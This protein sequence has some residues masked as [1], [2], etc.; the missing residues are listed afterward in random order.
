MSD[1]LW[2]LRNSMPTPAQDVVVWSNP[3]ITNSVYLIGG[4]TPSGAT[5]VV[6][7]YLPYTDTW[8]A[9]NIESYPSNVFGAACGGVFGSYNIVVAGG[10]NGSSALS[11][12]KGYQDGEGWLDLASMPSPKVFSTSQQ[13]NSM[14]YVIGG[15]IG[16]EVGSKDIY[17]FDV[18]SDVWYSN[19]SNMSVARTRACSAFN[20]GEIFVFGGRNNSGALSSCEKYNIA[21]DEWVAVASLPV[22]LYSACC[23]VVGNFAYV[24]GG[25][26][27][28][29][30][31]N[32]YVYAYSFNDN[33]WVV[34]SGDRPTQSSKGILLGYNSNGSIPGTVDTLLSV[35]GYN[36]SSI[37]SDTYSLTPGSQD[38]KVS[39][40]NTNI[41]SGVYSLGTNVLASCLT[42]GV[43]IY[44]TK[45]I[46]GIT[47]NDPVVGS[48]AELYTSGGIIIDSRD[49]Y[50][51]F[52]AVK[53]GYA[54]SN[55]LEVHYTV[56][57][58]V[59]N[60]S[61]YPT[62]PSPDV[63]GYYLDD[64][65]LTFNR[66]IYGDF[67]L[68][69]YDG[70]SPINN[71]SA[72]VWDTD[73]ANNAPTSIYPVYGAGYTQ[74]SPVVVKAV[75]AK[76]NP[77]DGTYYDFSDE[78]STT[79]NFK[80]MTPYIGY[81]NNGSGRRVEIS[82]SI[83]SVINSMGLGFENY[84]DSLY[85]TWESADVVNIPNIPYVNGSGGLIKQG[86]KLRVYVKGSTS[87]A[88]I[89]SSDIMEFDLSGIVGTVYYT[90]DGT[91]PALDNPNIKLYE[92]PILITSNLTLKFKVYEF[93]SG[94]NSYGR[95]SDTVTE[96][97]NIVG[98]IVDLQF[99]KTGSVLQGSVPNLPAQV[100]MI[101]NSGESIVKNIEWETVNT[102]ITGEQRVD[103]I[104]RG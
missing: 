102:D 67:V 42:S 88:N 75:S 26:L 70:S 33:A 69:T 83:P 49:T 79:F 7:R 103:G 2:V 45:S 24:V 48:N 13:Y 95:E 37:F 51:K 52:I 104:I 66:N 35:G 71:V 9:S 64:V 55:V 29:G 98:C 27:N 50:I 84:Y 78:V 46:T 74:K 19:L 31:I 76:Y 92:G 100:V 73:D 97:Y 82:V 62:T 68:W 39:D 47:P 89:L 20:S 54:N 59:P 1:N 40:V 41:A 22:G 63:N 96:V 60:I 81:I 18:L 77:V 23:C 65:L 44:Y 91:E 94:T 30:S 58:E 93:V 11:S 34:I 32:P 6:R 15:D 53:S 3:I 12:V 101:T 36:G 5:N 8:I 17:K 38:L 87:K 56:P 90:D 61:V 21:S 4:M 57:N 10:H 43:D 86:D 85:Y 25:I 16:S 72:F 28:D 99:N 80:L 14:L